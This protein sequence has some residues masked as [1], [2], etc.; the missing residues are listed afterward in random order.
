MDPDS[1]LPDLHQLA[2][3]EYGKTSQGRLELYPAVWSA[4]EAL[5]S[6]ELTTRKA[7]MAQLC[8]LGAAR[9]SPLLAYLIA[10]RLIEPDIELRLMIIQELVKVF[11][12]DSDGLLA[13]E[14]VRS[15]LEGYM[16]QMRTRQVFAL[17]EVVERDPEIAVS[18][19]RLFNECAYAGNHLIEIVL[20]R[21]IPV[22]YRRLGIYFLGV[23]GYVTALPALERL[24]GRLETR[25]NG[26]QAMPFIVNEANDEINLLPELRQTIDRLSA[27]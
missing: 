23:I 7:G 11:Q 19:V 14:K 9:F 8:E 22:K 25:M 5:A 17:L 1:Q 20:N 10:T 24:A 26:Q 15:T 4:A 21:N 16:C 3:F 6:P 12:P 27:P 2:F 18:V 13:P